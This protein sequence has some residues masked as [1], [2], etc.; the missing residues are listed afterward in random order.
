MPVDAQTELVLALSRHDAKAVLGTPESSWVDF[1]DPRA[2]TLDTDLRKWELAK[3]VAAMAN[4]DGGLLV[5]GIY[6]KCGVV[7]SGMGRALDGR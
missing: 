7:A 5:I 3:D 2:Y 6:A 4:A 1:K